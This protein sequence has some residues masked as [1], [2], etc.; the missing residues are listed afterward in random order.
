LFY[1]ASLFPL[2]IRFIVLISVIKAFMCFVK[3]M[4]N[5]TIVKPTIIKLSF[6]IGFEYLIAISESEIT[7]KIDSKVEKKLAI[8]IFRL[9][10][11]KNTHNTHHATNK[12]GNILCGN[13]GGDVETKNGNIIH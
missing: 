10:K 3:I 13:V 4:N 11:Y 6:T 12:N 5:N 8:I 9:Y 7:K 1:L 2:A